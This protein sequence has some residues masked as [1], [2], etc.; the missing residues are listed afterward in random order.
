MVN[1]S[2]KFQE[3][4]ITG[5]PASLRLL[6]TVSLYSTYKLVIFPE[7][8]GGARIRELAKTIKDDSPSGMNILVRP[9]I[10]VASFEG[11]ELMEETL[12]RWI[13]RVC[14]SHNRFDLQLNNFG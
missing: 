12:I 7:G 3:D 11:R 14:N 2:K 5:A 4:S 9:Y 10:Q 8:D 13:Q 6:P 1:L